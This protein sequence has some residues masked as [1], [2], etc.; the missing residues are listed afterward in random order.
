VI[1]ERVKNFNESQNFNGDQSS[2]RL[3]PGQDHADR[4]FWGYKVLVNPSTTEMLCTVTLE[5]LAMGKHVVIPEHPSNDFFKVNFPGRTH[6]FQGQDPISFAQA[7]KA[8]LAADGPKPLS[9]AEE[10]LLSWDSAI[11]RMLEAAE[12]RVLSGR[13]SR[14]SESRGSRMAYDIHKSFQT[15][16]PA[17]SELLKGATLKTENS[18]ERYLAGWTKTDSFSKVL[19]QVRKAMKLQK[20]DVLS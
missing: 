8:A 9:A 15:D 16:T 20:K 10:E 18:W 7:L 1:A 12:V 11:E 13:L 5:A 3:L 2:I 19:E 17:L 6:L 4:R 14:P